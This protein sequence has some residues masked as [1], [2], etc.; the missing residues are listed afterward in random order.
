MA[1]LASALKNLVT[2]VQPG[3]HLKFEDVADE[4]HDILWG[5]DFT[6]KLFLKDYLTSHDLRVKDVEVIQETLVQPI[7][8]SARLAIEGEAARAA[9]SKPG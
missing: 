7:A 6:S 8:A 2:H 3:R 4:L 9:L 1:S 5:K